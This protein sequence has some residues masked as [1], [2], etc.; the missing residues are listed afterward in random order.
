MS[1]R[2]LALCLLGCL[3]AAPLRADESLTRI[4][5]SGESPSAAQRLESARKLVRAGQLAEAVDE[6]Q[7]LLEEAGDKLA[8]L[9]DRAFVQVR[10]LCHLD[11]AALP[12][13]GLRLYRN[14]VDAQ[15]RRWFEQGAA[16]RDV[17]LL[18]RVVDEAFCS[19]YG[20][21]ALD[22]LGDLAFERGQFVEAER[23][24]RRLSPNVR[25]ARARPSLDLVYPD[26]RGDPA[27]PRAKQVLAR[28]F[29]PASE[30]S[31]AALR[32]ALDDYRRQHP[33]AA[34][35]LAGRTGTYADTLEALLAKRAAL[36]PAPA[37]WTSFGGGPARDRVL[38]AEPSDPNRLARLVR[39]WRFNLESHLRYDADDPFRDRAPS[40]ATA[41]ALAFHPLIAGGHVLT[42]DART[43]TA[44]DLRTGHADVWYD[45]AGPNAGLNADPALPPHA[46]LRHTLTVADGCVLARL[47][48]QCFG[49]ER[50]P[51]E[52]GSALVCLGLKPDARGER[53]RWLARPE[54][55]PREAPVFEGAPVAADGRVY[56]AVTRFA[57]GR[58][59]TA[60]HCYPLQ[61]E[62]TPPLRWRQDVCETP[63]LSGKDER[64]RHHLLT[65]AGPN[66]VY[67][68]HSGAVAALDAVT[69][70]HVWARRY[71][72]RVPGADDP[73]SPRDLAPPVYAGGRLYVAP[74]D[75][76]HLLCLDPATG[77]LLWERDGVEV[78]H[79]FGVSRGRLI[80]TTPQGIR[81]VDAVTGSDRGGWAQPDVGELP[82]FGRGFL[83][84]DL[85]FWPTRSRLYVL[86]AEDG[87]QP[88]DLHPG[89][90]QEIPP[91]NL[92][93]GDGCL[94]V[95]GNE[96]LTVYVPPAW[97]RA[98]REGEV[99][100]RPQSAGAHYEL[101][102]AEADAGRD[103]EA[104]AALDRAE[105]LTEPGECWQ[106]E[107]LRGQI[108]QARQRVLFA[109]ADRAAA[110]R[111][112]DDAAR[113]LREAAAADRPVRERLEALRREAAVWEA[114]GQPA[115]AV[116]VWQSV[117]SDPALRAGRLADAS[118]NPQ[119]AVRTA[120]REIGRLI[121]EHGPGVYGAAEGQA[122]ALLEA[123]RDDDRPA[124]LGRLAR[125]FP[126]AAAT[127]A[128]LLELAR[129]E[130]GAGHD[131]AA[132][133]ACRQLLRQAPDGA[134]A[135]AARAELAG[136][137]ERQRCRRAA[138][139]LRE[140]GAPCG[141]A[142]P[143]DLAL[144]LLRGWQAALAAEERLLPAH[145]A[146]APPALVPDDCA[147]APLF[148][149][150]GRELVYRDAADGR[151]GWSQSLPF[152]SDW[153]GRHAD[154]VV[155]AGPG[156]VRCLHL[157]DGA[158]L[159]SFP[160]AVRQSLGDFRLTASRLFCRQGER[161]AALDLE[162][163]WVL[164]AAA[165]PSAGLGL[166]YPSGR[167]LAYQAGDDW[168]VAQT[169]GGKLW[170]LEAGTGR[171]AHDLPTTREP[172]P[173]PPLALD[174]RHFCLVTDPATVVLL[175]AAA[176][177]ELARPP[178]VAPTTLS[179]RP[180]LAVG[181]GGVLLLV[182]DRNFG[183]TLQR[184][185]PLTGQAL[186]PSERLLGTD[187]VADGA[188]TFDREAVFAVSG[189]TLSAHALADGRAL[190]RVTLPRE[191]RDWRALRTRDY[192][193]A[194]PADAGDRDL[195]CR[196]LLGT[197][198]LVAAFGPL[199]RRAAGVPVLLVDPKTGRAV[200]RLNVPD[201]GPRLGVGGAVGPGQP[202]LALRLGRRPVALQLSRRGVTIAGAGRV[203][204][205][206]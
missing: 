191:G 200:Q 190:W 55:N 33:D 73:P 84:G 32:E 7:R 132:A 198:S 195:R 75:D 144:P 129:R 114:A 71:P 94:A 67:C 178:L 103:A 50:R 56:A 5:L 135:S 136:A 111:R 23:W 170:V 147:P 168:G 39:R 93:Y 42:A 173:R 142:D 40:P 104:L 76:D 95:A 3:T 6:Y 77:Q 11:L 175:D 60:V 81:A 30:V 183:P 90:W 172:W 124:V 205:G 138:R 164:W 105:R 160:P 199:E 15:A 204:G 78:V 150:R 46:D 130:A 9:D 137:Y 43:V 91:G 202:L 48:V 122:R 184:F 133:Q 88:D 101:A 52:S 203:A 59:V 125:E 16:T 180:P 181:A 177:K 169:A 121:R 27:R 162:S 145:V 141:T 186:W 165:A 44:Y 13:E 149:A 107:G 197:L 2:C 74:A 189:D 54:G 26:P 62:G 36:A 152:V 171:L 86:N 41:R 8:P 92:V 34:G 61:A 182:V 115:R 79:L 12:P 127:R 134:D 28:L 98:E 22:L 119:D 116:A 206:D 99:R 24:W 10:W 188:V 17:P 108:R 80:F 21:P 45:A 187:T 1:R 85:V 153:V 64:C 87:Q 126:N 38:P 31:N 156:G 117:L 155:A 96:V 148:F 35:A 51:D 65:L 196:T 140:P 166:P 131:G 185:D 110:E 20:D 57:G 128:T 193:V 82:P 14:R 37:G 161:L 68:S 146:G 151:V 100:L 109:A 66:V 97:L 113:A 19:R 118:G 176:G 139:A 25:D 163:G 4:V 112:W 157:D 18:R 123:A 167:F 102:L 154:A 29:R 120:A 194:Y 58:T 192:L 89:P 83:A 158:A 70:R 174:G 69:G 106:G 53:L 72:S 63:E 47:G 179:G 159:W 143:P 201:A 49:P